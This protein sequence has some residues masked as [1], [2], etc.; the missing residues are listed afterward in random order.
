[1]KT[2]QVKDGISIYW[3]DYELTIEPYRQIKK[4]YFCGKELL[5]FPDTKS[6]VYTILVVDYSECY[7]ANVYSDGE[8]VKLFGDTSDVPNK[9]KKGG[10]SAQRFQRAREGEIKKWFK[11]I[12]QWMKGVQSEN[13][14]LGISSIYYNRFKNHLS[15]YNQNKIKTNISTG[16]SGLTGIY[17]M[18]NT[19]EKDK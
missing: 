10:Q 1:M 12:N 13:I 2:S 16:Y 7:C 15:T 19:I 5:K 8:I 17:D 3:N 4:H 18:I 11:D 9:H 6:I 14:I